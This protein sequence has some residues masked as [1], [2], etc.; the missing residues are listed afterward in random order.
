MRFCWNTTTSCGIGSRRIDAAATSLQTLVNET[1]V[2][3]RQQGGDSRLAY[4]TFGYAG[5]QV[6]PFNND[7][8]VTLAAFKNII[9]DT[10]TPPTIPSTA[11]NGQ[12]NTAD[13]LQQAIN[14]LST[15]RTAR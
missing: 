14:L 11:L 1:L 4:V 13:G 10:N 2:V 6:I 8:S 7:P 3:Q 15:A 12:S 5:T 9:G